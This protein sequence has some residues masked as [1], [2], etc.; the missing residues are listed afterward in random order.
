[1]FHVRHFGLQKLFYYFTFTYTWDERS[2]FFFQAGL[3]NAEVSKCLL[4]EMVISKFDTRR[5]ALGIPACSGE[6]PEFN[7]IQPSLKCHFNIIFPILCVQIGNNYFHQ[8]SVLVPT[9]ILCLSEMKLAMSLHLKQML[10]GPVL[11]FR[12]FPGNGLF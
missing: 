7:D 6:L 4:L 3:V 12:D 10:I 11:G 8:H 2:I 9:F 5:P 1:M